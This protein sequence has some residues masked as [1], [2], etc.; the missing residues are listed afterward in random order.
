MAGPSNVGGGCAGA[1]RDGV[2]RLAISGICRP[3]KEMS[4]AKSVLLRCGF[5]SCGG[6]ASIVRLRRHLGYDAEQVRL[7]TVSSTEFW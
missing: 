7:L 3:D 5:R 2:T 1:E 4:D 6:C